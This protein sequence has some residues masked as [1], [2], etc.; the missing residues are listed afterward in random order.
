[1][2]SVLLCEGSTDYTLLQYYMRNAFGWEDDR[3]RQNG[4]F[5]LNGQ[6]SR[7]LFYGD[8]ILTIAS[9][10]GCSR[11]IEGLQQTLNRNRF[12]LADSGNI[13]DHIVII[14]DRDDIS[15]E[16]DFIEKVHKL[17]QEEMVC[18]KGDICNNQWRTCNMENNMGESVCFSLLLM[19]LP[20][21]GN[22]AMETFLLNAIAQEDAYDK[23]IIEKCNDFVDCA[24]P[25][26]RY[27]FK[28][29]LV[30][31]AKFDTYFS[32]RT[33]AEQFAER[34][35]ILKSIEWEKYTAL[36]EDFKLLEKLSGEK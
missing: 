13:F 26:K 6:K 20:F 14:T 23:E 34:Q 22:G 19:L 24:D 32:V 5:K 28:R 8:D 16:I 10:G 31:K 29:R 17:F 21:E 12:A 11:L 27:L 18:C 30:T 7:K 33:S 4:I 25:E 36:Q 2:N 15:T 3:N 1:M 35:N 9:V